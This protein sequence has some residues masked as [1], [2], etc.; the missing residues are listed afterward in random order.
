MKIFLSSVARAKIFV[1]ALVV[2]LPVFAHAENFK[3]KFT[4]VSETH[5]GT[6]VLAPGDYVLVMDSVSA[7]TKLIVRS[8]DGKASA[9][10]LSMWSAEGY[11]MKTNRLALETRGNKLFVSAAYLG[12]LET[13]LHFAVPQANQEVVMHEVTKAQSAT[14]SASIQ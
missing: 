12:D 10:V 14:I 4:L 11:R 9:M 6:A 8:A 13:E 7:P 2:M 1:L 5:W 3:G